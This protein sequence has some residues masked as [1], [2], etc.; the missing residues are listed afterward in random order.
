MSSR[1]PAWNTPID[2]IVKTPSYPVP[3]AIAPMLRN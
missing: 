1:L 2:E 3:V